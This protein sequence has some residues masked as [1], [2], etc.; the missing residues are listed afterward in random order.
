MGDGKQNISCYNNRNFSHR[1][2]SF[3]SFPFDTLSI[4]V[5]LFKDNIC[6]YIKI[7]KTI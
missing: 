4:N 7:H 6:M 3:H 5:Y 1:I 2:F